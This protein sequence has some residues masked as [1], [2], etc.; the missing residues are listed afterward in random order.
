VVHCHYSTLN[1][2]VLPQFNQKIYSTFLEEIRLI[3]KLE[4]VPSKLK[5][6]LA[7]I[8]DSCTR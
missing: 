6:P 2:I 1:D 3:H 4:C 7:I 8:S 5:S